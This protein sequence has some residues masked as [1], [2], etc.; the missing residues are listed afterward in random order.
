MKEVP[1]QIH[2]ILLL[3]VIWHP[4]LVSHR[5]PSRERQK[6]HVNSL[7]GGHGSVLELGLGLSVATY[8]AGAAITATIFILEL[9]DTL[10]QGGEIGH[11]IFEFAVGV[12]QGV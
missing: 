1:Y 9:E 6:L 10:R 12:L 2:S 11:V 4:G 8:R 7:H 5:R 3:L